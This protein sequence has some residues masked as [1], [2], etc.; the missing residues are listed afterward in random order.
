MK[1]LQLINLD[2]IISVSL[3]LECEYDWFRCLPSKPIF[4][5]FN[6]INTGKYTKE[7]WN[8]IGYENI[9]TSEE[10]IKKGYN[11]YDNKVYSKPYIYIQL[12]D[13]QSITYKFDTNEL[14][15]KALVKLVNE[16]EKMNIKLITNY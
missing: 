12:M 10:L 1:E 11:V 7:G 14:A 16:C 5:F 15:D 8:Q 4:K 13:K 2:K 9:Y 6:I 3:R